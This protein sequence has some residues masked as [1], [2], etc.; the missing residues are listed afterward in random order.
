MTQVFVVQVVGGIFSV[1]TNLFLAWALGPAG[2]GA[3]ALLVV[4]PGLVV[5]ATNLGLHVSMVYLAA[6]DKYPLSD[7]LST[8]LTMT[9]LI[10]LGLT[11]LGALIF[12]WLLESV[13]LGIPAVLVAISLTTL[14]SYLLAFYLGD[15]FWGLK[16]PLSYTIIRLLPVIV[17]F[18]FGVLLVGFGQLGVLGA[19]IAFAL[20]IH[21]SGAAALILAARAARLRLG[22]NKSL[23]TEAGRYGL[24]AYLGNLAQQ[25]A[26]RIDLPMVNYFAGLGPAGYYSIAVT[27]A[28]IV[29]YIPR[30]I[31]YVIFVHVAGS[32]AREADRITPLMIRAALLTSALAAVAFAFLSHMLITLLL[33]SYNAA[34]PL[35][36]LLL[37]GV[38]IANVFHVIGNDL[39]GRGRPML[40][41]LIAFV[42]LGCSVVLYF[43][44]IPPLGAGGAALAS[45]LV[46]A[47]EAMAAILILSQTAKL[48]IRQ[49]LVPDRQDLV[50]FQTL[51]MRMQQLLGP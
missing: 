22:L 19:T 16:R 5:I 48:S 43:V 10:S 12:P 24:Q 39:M 49:L 17:Y 23:I 8:T 4:V 51:R 37:P 50:V 21:S 11:V 30:S 40:P 36:W 26:Y 20:G 3:S 18:A 2:K 27:L 14:P 38:V 33:P 46:Y 47:L 32:D 31:G 9:C 41:T 42:G 29:W 45:S 35:L 34:L 44:L 25:S 7:L 1:L 6:K 28:E 13:F 15:I